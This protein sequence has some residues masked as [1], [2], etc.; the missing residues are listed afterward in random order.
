MRIG[1]IG[2][3]RMGLAVEQ[4]VAQT[5]HE[6]VFRCDIDNQLTGE[7]AA[8]AEVM[9]D[10]STARC[11]KQ[12]V[13]LAME[14]GIP[15][16]TGTTGWQDTFDA[17]RA[18]VEKYNGS[19]LHAANFS[20]GVALFRHIVALAS[21]S[22]AAFENYDLAI[23]ESHHNGKIDCPSG[24][25]LLLAE[26]VL[27]QLPRKK[28]LV[29]GNPD[30]AISPAELQISSSRIGSVPG[31]HRVFIDSAEDTIELK[32]VARG[33]AGFA[34]GAIR[35]AEWLADKSGFYSL[36]DMLQD[37]LSPTI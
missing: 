19:F 9:I 17:V 12:N 16:V 13:V 33:R 28:K 22:I 34:V 14:A 15:F 10:F 2:T 18:L 32:H 1:L 26:T 36:E 20:I 6:I 30:G 24:T 5:S 4:A 7:I 29:I 11:I 35:A 37:F 3:G 8:S 31:T 21:R 27:Q 25:A 23:H